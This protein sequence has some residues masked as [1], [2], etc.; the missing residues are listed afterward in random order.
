MPRDGVIDRDLGEKA[1]LRRLVDA[2]DMQVRVGYLSGVPRYPKKRKRGGGKTPIARVAA[3][4]GLIKITADVWDQKQREV[5]AEIERAHGRI[6]AGS[7]AAQALVPVGEVLRDAIRDQ[8]YTNVS[9]DTGRLRAG[10]RSAV[11]D[12]AKRVAG[13]DHRGPK[14]S[15]AV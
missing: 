14:A 5:M 1:I 7:T 3:V 10:V 12:G 9:E 15:E 2:E 6:I 4:H 13:D 11:F 8:V